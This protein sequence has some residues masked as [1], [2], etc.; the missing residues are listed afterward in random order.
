MND[1]SP[2]P[3]LLN[4]T[5]AAPLHRA[6]QRAYFAVLVGIALTL[7]FL[8]VVFAILAGSGKEA[9]RITA[10]RQGGEGYL[11]ALI[12]TFAATHGRPKAL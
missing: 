1:P 9:E 11:T 8:L 10:S 6:M 5:N 12:A 2:N 3:V 7:A 4:E